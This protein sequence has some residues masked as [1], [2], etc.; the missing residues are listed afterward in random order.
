MRTI[1]ARVLWL[2]GFADQAQKLA[3]ETLELASA[4]G[5]VPWVYCHTLAAGVCPIAFW[6]GDIQ[7]ASRFTQILVDFSRRYAIRKY[8]EVGLCYQASVDLCSRNPESVEPRGPELP[9]TTW[10]H[11]LYRDTL[12]TFCDYW[13]DQTACDRAAN[14][15]SGWASAEILRLDALR[16]WRRDPSSPAVI[17]SCLN[18]SLRIA[19]DQQAL[20]WELRTTTSIAQLWLAQGRGEEALAALLAV[21]GRFEEGHQT[22]DLK[23]AR[24]LIEE[25]S[26]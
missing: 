24:A 13:V 23:A 10:L 21:Y 4:E 15:Q 5:P 25:I 20:A 3:K 2:T 14:G 6:R 8:T 17:E 26:R 16:Q 7:D 12:T 1:L 19:R 11:G 18:A 9:D 22:V